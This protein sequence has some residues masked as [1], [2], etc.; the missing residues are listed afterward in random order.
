VPWY[1]VEMYVPWSEY[2]MARTVH[3]LLAISLQLTVSTNPSHVVDTL[4]TFK[5]PT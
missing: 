3:D 2:I 1:T 4:H 5:L